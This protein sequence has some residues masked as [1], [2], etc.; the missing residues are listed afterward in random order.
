MIRAAVIGCGPMGQRHA[1]KL[2]KMKDVDLVA[3]CDTN[4]VRAERLADEVGCDSA[5][6]YWS[7]IGDLDCAVVA[8]NPGTHGEICTT[9]LNEM[10]HVLVEKPIATSE[11]EAQAMTE[12]ADDNDLVLQVGHIER[13]N[14]VF[15]RVANVVRYPFEIVAERYSTPTFQRFDVDVVLDLMIH[16]ID[17]VLALNKSE[18]RDITGSGNRETAIAEVQFGDGSVAVLRAD[19]NAKTRQR[20]WEVNQ[21]KHFLIGEYDSLTDELKHFL[22]CIREGRKPEVGGEEGTRALRVALE[23]SSQVTHAL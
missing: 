16:D 2:K 6:D 20:V 15:K 12:C 23:I 8:T 13:F 18:I 4:E 9:L 10:V 5:E 3:V 14:P 7:L 11:K 1:H 22:T 21:D 17:M 19:R